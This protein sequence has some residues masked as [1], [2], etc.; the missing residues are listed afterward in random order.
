M[1][2][3]ITVPRLRVPGGVS[4]YYRVIRPHLDKDKIY[5][6]IGSIP[7]DSGPFRRV[8]R[9]AVDYARFHRDL[10]HGQFDLVHLNP[11]MNLYAVLR[12]AVFLLIALAHRKK[13]LVFY[14]GWHPSAE[15]IVRRRFRL[16]FRAI[17]GRAQ[18]TIVLASEFKETLLELGV[19]GP[20]FIETTIVEDEIFS[21]PPSANAHAARSSGFRVLFLS[22]LDA[23][24]GLPEAL[25]AYALLRAAVPDA[26]LDIAGDG[27]VREQA[28]R[29]VRTRGLQGVH[30]LGHVSG[31]EKRSALAQTDVYLFTSHAEGMPNSVL[32]AMAHGL[33]VVTRPVGGLR[34]FF[35]DGVMGYSVDSTDPAEFARRLAQLAADPALRE[36]MGLYNRDYAR[37]RFAASV[38]ATRLLAI[39]DT[40]RPASAS[41]CASDANVQ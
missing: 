40:L 4:N 5:F 17:Y 32:E 9:L 26:T 29:E 36:T 21:T 24:K 41:C 38:V 22:R 25:D 14:R 8:W 20:F 37:R 31:S 19:P 27:P 12:D 28:E 23:G 11:S 1:R 10:L 34:D 33:P 16:L 3:L 35:A 15:A 13:V 18:A 7:G 39:Y 2:V 30:F 6:E